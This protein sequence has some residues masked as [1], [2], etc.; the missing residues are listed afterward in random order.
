MSSRPISEKKLVGSR[1]AGPQGQVDSLMH[2]SKNWAREANKAAMSRPGAKIDAKE[3][4]LDSNMQSSNR[5]DAS[6]ST[7]LT[8]LV[9]QA[10]L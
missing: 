2:K 8:G 5:L 10:R 3:L 4:T 6:P 7:G 9:S 1:I